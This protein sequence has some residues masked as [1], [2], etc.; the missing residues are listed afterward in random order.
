MLTSLWVDAG[1][2]TNQVRPIL[3]RFCFPAH[4]I[5]RPKHLMEQRRQQ[6]PGALIG[7]GTQLA[8]FIR[9]P[10]D[11]DDAF[12]FGERGRG[13]GKFSIKLVDDS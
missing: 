10:Q 5:G 8:Q 3:R 9:R 13:I 7:P 11:L 1:T 12:L 6:I 2:P 4:A